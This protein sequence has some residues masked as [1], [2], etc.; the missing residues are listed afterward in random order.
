MLSAQLGKKRE[1]KLEKQYEEHEN[2]YIFLIKHYNYYFRQKMP[3]FIQ[4]AQGS[5]ID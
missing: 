5:V 3:F 2:D 1:K 4:V